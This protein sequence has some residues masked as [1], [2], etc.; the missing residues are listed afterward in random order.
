MNGNYRRGEKLLFWISAAALLCGIFALILIDE[1]WIKYRSITIL[2]SSLIILLSF[3]LILGIDLH[4]RS[5]KKRLWH[6]HMATWQEDHNNQS[7]P[8]YQLAYLLS[9][10]ALNNLAKQVYSEMG[11]TLV[12]DAEADPLEFIIK[13][14][15]PIGEIEMVLCKQASEPLGLAYIS[16]MQIILNLNEAVRGFIW[17]PGGF[18]SN[19]VHY[20]S[21]KPIILADNLEIG[22]FV[23]CCNLTK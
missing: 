23:D 16:N 11:Y 13:L 17:A 2:T 15:N 19:A 18:A 6:R 3:S 14:H 21:G 7:I 22:R 9:D 20:A 10:G 4:H 1:L 8:S 12:E 5:Q